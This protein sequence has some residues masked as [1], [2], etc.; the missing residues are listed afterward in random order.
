MSTM[1]RNEYRSALAMLQD[2]LEQAV[3]LGRPALS[4]RQFEGIERLD[5]KLRTLAGLCRETFQQTMQDAYT[6]IAGKLERGDAL[7]A[8]ERAAVELLFTGEA[9]YYL[10]TENNF[11]DWIDELSRLVAELERRREEGLNSLA[12]LMHVQALCRDAMHVTPEVIYYL[13]EKQRVDQFRENLSGEISRE[14]GYL[15]GRMIRDLMASP[16]R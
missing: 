7:T 4:A 9:M 6:H 14:G 5:H 16:H 10:K 3:E 11:D 1:D 8:G 13:R 2:T 15:L 12:D